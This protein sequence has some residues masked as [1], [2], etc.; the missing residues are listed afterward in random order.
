MNSTATQT[1]DRWIAI[2]AT[3]APKQYAKLDKSLRAAIGWAYSS[4]GPR[5][6]IRYRTTEDEHNAQC[7]FGIRPEVWASWFRSPFGRADWNSYHSLLR[8]AFAAGTLS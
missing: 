6:R 7:P 5:W 1:E 3:M 4:D 8:D 2:H